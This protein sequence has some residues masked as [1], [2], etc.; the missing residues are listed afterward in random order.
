MFVDVWAAVRWWEEWQ[1]RILVMLSLAVQWILLLA[2]PLRRYTIPQWC[3]KCIWL[4]YVGSDALA[5]YALATLF[6]R[7][8]KAS[9]GGNVKQADV[10]E[11]LWAP[12]LLIHLGGQRELTAYNIED[13]E[14]WLRHAVTL[15][16]QVA[17][18]LYAFY[19]SWP[20]STDPRLLASAI[21]LFVVGV[22]SFSEKPWAFR[23]ARINRLAAVSALIRGTKKPPNKLTC[24]CNELD[25]DQE[26]KL[27]EFIRSIFSCRCCCRLWMW[28]KRRK[29]EEEEEGR[30]RR[31]SDDNNSNNIKMLF[32][33]KNKVHMILSDMSLFAAASD[34]KRSADREHDKDELYKEIL[35]RPIGAEYHTI[36]WLSSAY[37]LIYTR[38]KVVWTPAYLAYHLLLVPAM[39]GAALTLFVLSH[40]RGRYNP[41]DIK[42][43]YVLLCLTAA[44]DT[45][46]MFVVGAVHLVMLWFSVPS[47]CEWV[48]QYNLIDAVLRRRK[49]PNR[50]LIKCASWF[51]CNEEYFLCEQG[52][53]DNMLYNKVAGYLI[54]DLV[55]NNPE[56]GLDVSTY[57]NLDIS[58]SSNWALDKLLQD[59]LTAP[60]FGKGTQVRE[61]LLESFDKS[62]LL[63]H[64]ATDLCFCLKTPPAPFNHR[65]FRTEA[66]SNY[67]AHLLKF[68]PDMLMT[69]TRQHLFTEATEHIQKI[70]DNIT[71]TLPASRYYNQALAGAILD[72]E[73]PQYP[74]IHEACQ[75]A[76][77]LLKIEQET[78]YEL[79][80]RV[81]L[82]MLFYSAAMC[83]G[84]L[85]AKSLGEGGEFLSFV[86]L[87]LSITGTRTL[88]DKLQ[89]CDQTLTY[90][91]KEDLLR[92]PPRM[93]KEHDWISLNE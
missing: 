44:M 21:L 85:H 22:F 45:L 18:A 6:N 58:S 35:E 78:L 68:R 9:S 19:K 75:L 53:G 42:T 52:R 80:Y 10:L 29:Q 74:L 25:E 24:C 77:E 28:S 91:D 67:M 38:S 76:R 90:A 69:G 87:L 73:C 49:K 72:R 83:R 46:G 14:L 23:R 92:A 59:H 57:R 20:N 47:L 2:A 27:F 40:K 60:L 56:K 64:L 70:L 79:L 11:I 16:S 3:R 7:H 71:G 12:V 84:Y 37:R 50:W 4:A 33:L 13:N 82:G 62:V 17:V 15:V 26:Y 51:S 8:A 66:I 5:I 36:G 32:S 88:A 89:M 34:L 65:E 30:R 41:T 54:I 81:W 31:R 55:I 1:L 86:W 48:A 39:H 43:T 61:T 63:W 93:G